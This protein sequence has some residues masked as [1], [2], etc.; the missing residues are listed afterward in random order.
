MSWF[1]IYSSIGWIIAVSMILTVLQRRFAPGAAWAWLGIVFLHP[2]IGGILYVL[3]GETRFDPQRRALHRQIVEQFRG[4]SENQPKPTPLLDPLYQPMALQAEKISGLPIREG[5]S[6]EFITEATV[7]LDRLVADIDAA[8]SQ[9]HLLYYIF[10]PD[11]TGKKVADALVR[12]AGRGVKCRVLVDAVASRSFFH[13]RHGLAGRLNGAGVHVAAALRVAN[14]RRGLPRMDM[15]NHRKLAIIDESLAYAGSHNLINADYGGR[16]GGPWYDLTGRFTGPVV[17]EFQG[18]FCEDWAFEAGETITLGTPDYASGAGSIPMQVVPTG[19]TDPRDTYRHVLLAAIQ[20][21]RRELILTTPY[22][23]PDEPTLVALMM[24]ADRGVD[25][26]L[27]LP[28]R[29]DHLF[30]AAAGRANFT[31]LMDAG[32][33]IYLYRPGL[34]HSKSATVDDAFVLFGSANLDV[35]SFN[36]NFELS[37]LLYGKEIT[38]KAR[39][40]Q[41]KYLSES[42]QLNL[43]EWTAR[44]VIKRYADG[45]ISLLSPLL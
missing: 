20:C 33:S 41:M 19:P 38:E 37:V 26:K 9:V 30:T 11:A 31:A 4:K 32:I 6:I 27:I 14:F 1:L 2:Y 29:P 18:V 7:L 45:A 13:R 39:D 3:V 21:A 12:A 34:L 15:R 42:S 8:K 28:D 22:F 36:I 5:N 24:A 10:A 25:V 40:V 35:R 16:Y 44:P 43:K 17:G 23:V